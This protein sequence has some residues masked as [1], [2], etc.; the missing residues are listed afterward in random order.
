MY[1]IDIHRSFHPETV[2]YI[3]FSSSHGTFS[4][5]DDMFGNMASLN[6]FKK[7]KIIYSIFTDHNVMKQEIKYKKKIWESDK[8]L[9][10]K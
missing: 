10:I 4:K 2:Q 6:K 8:C 7:I 9:E 1:L 5:I 3:F